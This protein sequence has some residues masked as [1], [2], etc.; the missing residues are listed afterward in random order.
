MARQSFN[1]N[2]S[3][4]GSGDT[5]ASSNRL[6]RE[7]GAEDRLWIGRR[8]ISALPA[9]ERPALGPGC[10]ILIAAEQE[11]TA[12]ADS[13]ARSAD[14]GEVASVSVGSVRRASTEA[15]EAATA[16]TTRLVIPVVLAGHLLECQYRL[17]GFDDLE[18]EVSAGEPRRQGRLRWDINELGPSA[19]KTSGERHAEDRLFATDRTVLNR[20]NRDGNAPASEA[21]DENAQRAALANAEMI[22]RRANSERRSAGRESWRVPSSTPGFGASRLGPAQ[23]RRDPVRSIEHSVLWQTTGRGDRDF[24]VSLFERR[25]FPRDMQAQGATLRLIQQPYLFRMVCP[26][27]PLTYH[28]RIIAIDWL[29][30]VRVFLHSGCEFSFEQPFVVK[31]GPN[32]IKVLQ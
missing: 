12:V 6:I 20:A 3:D 25:T 13:R 27:S 17:F 30:R 18:G 28:G 5:N 31:A 11:R 22:D 1:S 4:S 8:L 15:D 7:D 23:T 21:K 2:R 29:V 19:P 32:P 24:G 10:Q 14:G 9:F 26:A 16:E